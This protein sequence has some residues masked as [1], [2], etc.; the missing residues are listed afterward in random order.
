MRIDGRCH[1][2]EITWTAE[3][4]PART[5]ICHCTDCQALSGAPYRASVACAEEDLTLQTGT[6]ASYVKTTADSG[7]ARLQ[8]F[9]GTCGAPLWSTA[10]EGTGRTF[11]LRLGGVEQRADLVPQRQVFTGSAQPWVRDLDAIPG[12]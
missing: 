3:V 1:C 11:M 4:D 10:P 6:P 2:G 7:N 12:S 5:M 8:T 9:C